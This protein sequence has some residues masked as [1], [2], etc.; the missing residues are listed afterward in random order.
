MAQTL[1][2]SRLPFAFVLLQEVL[3]HRPI[4]PTY[5]IRWMLT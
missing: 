5:R 3:R 4:T 2:V 1:S